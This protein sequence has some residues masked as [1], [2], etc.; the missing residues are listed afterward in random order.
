MTKSIDERWNDSYSYYF[1]KKKKKINLFK[2]L[3]LLEKFHGNG[4]SVAKNIMVFQQLERLNLLTPELLDWTFKNKSDNSYTPFGWARYG[5]IRSYKEYVDF[6]GR[7]PFKEKNQTYDEIY[8]TEYK[9]NRDS[10]FLIKIRNLIKRI[11]V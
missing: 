2:G 10:H 9:N 5:H 4:S 1:L 3:I 7:D 11:F 8:N 6:L